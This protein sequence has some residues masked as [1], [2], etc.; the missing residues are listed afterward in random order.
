MFNLLL[1]FVQFENATIGKIVQALLDIGRLDVISR[2]R[3]NL[4]GN[5]YI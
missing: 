2:I 4:N 1:A 3:N 5:I